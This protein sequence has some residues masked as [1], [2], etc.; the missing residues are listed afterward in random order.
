VSHDVWW[1]AGTSACAGVVILDISMPATSPDMSI[2]AIAAP[3]A[4]TA[5]GIAH[6]KPLPAHSN[7]AKSKLVRSA[8]I[9]R[10]RRMAT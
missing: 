6:A 5:L 1:C 3:A 7:W 9:R 10:V 8:K 2:P 4:C